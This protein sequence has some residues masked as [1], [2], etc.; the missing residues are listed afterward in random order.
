MPPGFQVIAHT[1][2]S[3]I[4]GIANKAKKIYGVQFHPEV[5]HTE[6]GNQILSNFLFKVCSCSGRW[7]MQSFI[8]ESIE[9]IRKTVGK[10]KVVL[11]LSGGADSSVAAL[12]VHKAIGKNCRC[13]FIDNGLLR[14]D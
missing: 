7:T 2:N 14:E 11:G 10:S 4:A 13:I 6:K 8:K 5:T 3:P 1:T 12:L 9:N